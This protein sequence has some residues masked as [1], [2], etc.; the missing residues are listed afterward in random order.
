MLH[1][2]HLLQPLQDNIKIFLGGELLF[3]FMHKHFLS[4]IEIMQIVHMKHNNFLKPCGLEKN[5]MYF[6]NN[7]PSQYPNGND[8]GGFAKG[9]DRN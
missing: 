4:F 6:Q 2:S 8:L 3:S 9:I 5:L 7:I 1:I